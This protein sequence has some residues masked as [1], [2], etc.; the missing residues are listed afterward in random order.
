MFVK[1]KRCG[2]LKGRRCADGRKLRDNFTKEETA[3]PTVALKSVHLP[4]A[5]DAREGR[6]EATLDLPNA[7]MQTNIGDECVLMKLRG[8]FAEL[9]V[10]VAPEMHSDYVTC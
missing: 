10:R 6:H 4:S 8:S 5:I 7:F 2:R 1:H 9:M 3:S